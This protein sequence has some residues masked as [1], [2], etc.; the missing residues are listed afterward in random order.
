MFRPVGSGAIAARCVR[1]CGWLVLE[2]AA[3]A[4]LLPSLSAAQNEAPGEAVVIPGATIPGWGAPGGRD[5][6]PRNHDVP[7]R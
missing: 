6:H 5:R 3:A 1:G 4:L 2:A 7:A